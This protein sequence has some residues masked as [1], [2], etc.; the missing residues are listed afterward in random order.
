MKL[1]FDIESTL[2]EIHLM[3]PVNQSRQSLFRSVELFR[4]RVGA[5]GF[6]DKVGSIGLHGAPLE[7]DSIGVRSSEG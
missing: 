2:V 1:A 4:D 6:F 5:G 3:C 7:R